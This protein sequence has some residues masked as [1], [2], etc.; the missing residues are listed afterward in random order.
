M[1]AVKA[2]YDYK[3][4]DGIICIEDLNRGNRSVT[5]DIE[6][7]IEQI[8]YFENIKNIKI[9][10]YRDSEGNWDG[11][12]VENDAFIPLVTKSREIAIQKIKAL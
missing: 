2:D 6:N 7:V 4:I 8:K 9:V 3:I 10:I 12:V 5:N 11:Y 1:V